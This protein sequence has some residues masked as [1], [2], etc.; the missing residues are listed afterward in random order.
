MATRDYY[1]VLG[2][3]RNATDEELKKAFRAQARK[4]H[5]DANPGDSEAENR[6]KELNEAYS[7][8]SDPQ[9]RQQ[10][11][12]FGTAEP[13]GFSGAGFEDLGDIFDMFFGGG[14]GAARG[15]SGPQR[16]DD[17]RLDVELSLEEIVAG[18]EK[19]MEVD[20][21]EAC[22][23]CHGSGAKPGTK[24][25]SC[26][27][28]GGMGQVQTTR[29]TPFGRFVTAQTCHVC[30]GQGRVIAAACPT[31]RG[32]GR[33]T[34]QKPLVIKIPPGAVEGTRIRL[35]GEGGAGV[36]GGPPG[37]LYLF[38]HEKRD[39]VFVRQ[40]RNLHYAQEISFA[41]AALGAEVQVPEIGGGTSKLHIP[42]GTQNGTQFTIRGQ[43]V[44]NVRG[45][46][47]GD[48]IVTVQVMIPKDLNH[49]EQQLIHRLA[50]I[51]GEEI[52]HSDKGFLKKV[53]DVFRG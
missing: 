38:V 45:H 47:R 4:H 24:P 21:D 11:D 31:C 41:Q 44:P 23:T 29:Q 48:L 6:F 5:P 22:E 12:H 53:K 37:D 42:G 17:L 33:K 16:G 34:V 14:G 20:R 8:L 39:S 1:E 52:A 43:G 50:E 27:T 46:G 32:V 25:E 18:V 7:V 35:T 40:E 13:G 26:R 2:V 30:R 15:R 19:T 36:Q 28:C 51:R 49:E 10:Y 3:S 9:K